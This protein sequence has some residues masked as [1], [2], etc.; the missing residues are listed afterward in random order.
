MLFTACHRNHNSG[1]EH[2]HDHDHET[3]EQHAHNGDAHDVHKP[4]PAATAESGHAPG[5][6]IVLPEQAE[7]AGLRVEAVLPKPFDMVIKTSGQIQAAQ[8]DELTVV[9]PSNGIVSFAR[10]LNEGVAVQQGETL[11]TISSQNM[12]EGDPVLKAKLTYE[13]AEREY[14]RATSLVKDTLISI[15]EYEQA[16]TAYETAGVAWEALAKNRTA[17]GVAVTAGIGGYIKSRVVTEGAYVTTGQPLLILSKNRRLQLRCDVPEKYYSLLETITSA[18]FRTPYNDTLYQLSDLNGS[19]I[20][21]G[22]SAEAA[23]FYIPVTFAFDP[24]DGIAPGAFVEVYL[25]SVPMG[26]VLTVPRQ[27][28][29]EEQGLYFVYVQ[30]AHGD[31]YLKREVKPGNDNGRDVHILTGL[32]TGEKVVVSGAMYVKLASNASSIPE[33]GHSH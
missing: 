30:T 26:N 28:M 2:D 31:A 1:N 33:H 8:G 13:Q 10:T 25:A 19:L 3:H 5:E 18:N 15:R 7:A 23:S 4:E 14:R 27:A 22:R 11:V 16:R 9:A 24:V 17:T 12:L 29:I 6:I 32:K 21:Y 20:A